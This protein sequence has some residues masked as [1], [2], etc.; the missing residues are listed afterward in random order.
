MSPSVASSVR[1]AA[2]VALYALRFGLAA[3]ESAA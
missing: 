3:E 2:F 1:D